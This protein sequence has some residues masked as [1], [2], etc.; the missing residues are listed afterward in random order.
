M[1]FAQHKVASGFMVE[2][3]YDGRPLR[4][5]EIEI[6][7]EIDKEPY[8]VHVLSTTSNEK[9]Q[10]AVRGL[11]PGRYFL[12]V[13]HAGVGG[14]AVELTVVSERE[15][16]ASV[17]NS[18]QLSWPNKKV[19]K[20][21]RIAGSLFRTPFDFTKHSA[22]PPL[23]GSKLTLTDALS[24]TQQSVSVV[25]NDGSFAFPDITAGFY[26]LHIKQEHL[27]ELPLD[28]EEIE[29]NVFVEVLHDAKDRALPTL[30]LY[31]SDCGLGMRGKDGNEVF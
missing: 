2:T 9:G 22:E 19:F 7:R 16:D 26:V 12:D 20:V 30:R 17:E 4:G 29:G 5:I 31:M 6:S 11:A 3:S 27:T 24:G 21:R 28:R 8:L 13:T 18:L 10:S 15:A 25:Q 14:E 1:G 23:A